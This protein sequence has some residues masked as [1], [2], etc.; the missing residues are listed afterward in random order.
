MKSIAPGDQTMAG[1]SPLPVA[2]R[3]SAAQK[4]PMFQSGSQETGRV[5][6]RDTLRGITASEASTAN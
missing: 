4:E 1:L 3:R 2:Q 6:D 5:I